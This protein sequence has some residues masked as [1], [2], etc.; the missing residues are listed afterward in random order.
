M[1]EV[2][3]LT[4]TQADIK[5]GNQSPFFHSLVHAVVITVFL[6]FFFYPFC[7][8]RNMVVK[9]HISVQNIHVQMKNMSKH[10]HF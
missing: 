2:K 6:R 4:F 7:F 10:A 1:S 3:T 8:W 5:D 9:I